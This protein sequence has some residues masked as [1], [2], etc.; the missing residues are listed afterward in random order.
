MTQTLFISLIGPFR[1]YFYVGFREKTCSEARRPCVFLHKKTRRC[2]SHLRVRL[3]FSW[4]QEEIRL[5]V[6]LFVNQLTRPYT[7]TSQNAVVFP[8]D[9]QILILRLS[10]KRCTHTREACECSSYSRCV[11]ARFFLKQGALNFLL[12]HFNMQKICKPIPERPI[13][14]KNQSIWDVMFFRMRLMLKTAGLF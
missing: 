1:V 14:V 8:C 10:G 4:L 12:P 9:S 2:T 7:L 13:I 11:S 6:M 5:K 3:L